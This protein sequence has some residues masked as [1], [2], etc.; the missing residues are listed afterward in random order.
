MGRPPISMCT[1]TP[2]L[3]NFVVMSSS[4]STS[5]E[6][7]VEFNKEQLDRLDEVGGELELHSTKYSS[8]EYVIRIDLFKILRKLSAQLKIYGVEFEKMLLVGGGASHVANVKYGYS[9]IDVVISLRQVARSGEEEDRLFYTISLAVDALLDDLVWN[10]TSLGHGGPSSNQIFDPDF[11]KKGVLAKKFRFHRNMRN[12]TASTDSWSLFAL[13]NKQG[14]DV[15][16]K[17]VLRMARDYEYATDS[18]KIDVVPRV[19]GTSEKV[20]MESGFGDVRRVLYCLENRLIVIVDPEN[21]LG[22]GLLKYIRLLLKKFRLENWTSQKARALAKIMVNEF[23]E[24]WNQRPETNPVKSYLDAHYSPTDF[25]FRIQF[26]QLLE[27]CCLAVYSNG[28]NSAKLST[29]IRQLEEQF[30][31]EELEFNGKLTQHVSSL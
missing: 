25:R 22:E 7:K 15:E 16:L 31:R 8:T 27:R 14:R 29:V 9:D 4:P 12:P 2:Q 5:Q 17:F 10:H 11:F 6:Q 18:L 20:M 19:Q 24:A 13:H 3:F 21:V 23:F 30:K 1:D 28:T 26:L